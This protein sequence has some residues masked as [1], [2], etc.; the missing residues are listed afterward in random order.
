[1]NGVNLFLYCLPLLPLLSRKVLGVESSFFCAPHCVTH[2]LKTGLSCPSVW[3]LWE[4][5]AFLWRTQIYFN[6]G[7][8]IG[9]ATI[10]YFFEVRAGHFAN[11][12]KYEDYLFFFNVKIIC[13]HFCLLQLK[14][15]VLLIFAE[16][17]YP[18][19]LLIKSSCIFKIKYFVMFSNTRNKLYST[20]GTRL[21]VKLI[22]K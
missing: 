3:S 9:P 20:L 18:D 21:N 15:N 6:A 13:T 5:Q 8:Q 11:M 17:F 22:I 1:M 14:I 2:V 4:T 19:T 12:L 16:T 10:L 7:L